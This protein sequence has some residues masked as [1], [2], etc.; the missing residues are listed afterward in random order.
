MND[1]IVSE[2]KSEASTVQERARA[3]VINDTAT[4]QEAGQFLL[5]IKALR[6]KISEFCDPVISLAYKTHREAVAKKN[7]MEAPLLEAEKLLEPKRKQYIRAE[8]EKRRTEELRIQAEE[9]KKAEDA[10]LAEAISLAAQGRK[11]ESERVIEMPIVTIPVVL[12]TEIPKIKGL[13]KPITYWKFKIVDPKLIPREYMCPD[14][15]KIGQ[16]VRALKN[17]TN[18]PGIEAYPG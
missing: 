1:L 15:V 5:N 16:L 4:Y 13:S 10:R 2:L 7:E 3:V 11:A 12:P 18:I 6:K 17:A 8:E 9:R 14:E